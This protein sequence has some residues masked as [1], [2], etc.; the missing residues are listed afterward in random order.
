[1]N[2]LQ[3]VESM[4]ALSTSMVEA[5]RANDWDRLAQLEQ[6]LA[7]LR[8][9][10]ARL[11]PGGRQSE[12]LS[13]DDRRRKAELVARMLADGDEIRTHVEPWM[14]SA[15]RVLSTDTRARTMRAAY[16]AMTP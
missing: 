13:E 16:G 10:L 4:S 1:M 9:E 15:R 2:S 8:N 7:A 14:E 6:Q 5:A 11:E 3:L 12:A